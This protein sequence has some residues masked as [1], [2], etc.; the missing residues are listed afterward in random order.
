M[1]VAYR[2]IGFC[3]SIATGPAIPAM[4]AAVISLQLFPRS[5]LRKTWLSQLGAGSFPVRSHRTATV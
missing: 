5:E 1:K 3:G 4:E 2:I